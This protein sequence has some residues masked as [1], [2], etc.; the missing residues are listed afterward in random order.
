EACDSVMHSYLG[1]RVRDDRKS[2]LFGKFLSM[3]DNLTPELQQ[4]FL[5]RSFATSLMDAD[6]IE[7]MLRELAFDDIDR[8]VKVFSEQS[9]LLPERLKILV[10]KLRAST[11]DIC[12]ELQGGGIS[13]VDD[14]EIDERVAKLLKQDNDS[15]PVDKEY[16]EELKKMLGN[17][18]A[19][20]DKMTYEL[21][22]SCKS[23]IV[24]RTVSKIMFAL[25]KVESNS[26]EEYQQLL[27]GLLD[28]ADGFIETGRFSDI[29]EIY[30][31][32]R[33]HSLSGTFREEASRAIKDFFGSQIFLERLVGAFRVWGRFNTEEV[34]DLSIILKSS[35]ITPLLDA[36]SAEEN[37][38]IRRFFLDV[39]CRMGG[40][41]AT[42]AARRLDDDRWYVTRNMVHL[43]RECNGMEHVSRIRQFVKHP[44]E[45]VAMEAVRTLLHF[46][47]EDATSY[48][49]LYLQSKNPL[50]KEQ[51]ARLAGA[52]K[53]KEAVPYL[54]KLL[55]KKDMLGVDSQNKVP[56]VK[57]LGEIGEPSALKILHKICDSSSLLHKD[58]L[59]K[60]KI[61]IF[62][63]L[64]NYPIQDVKPLLESGLMSK[65]MDIR[66]I[67][68]RLLKRAG[69]E[70]D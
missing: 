11:S 3:V 21:E 34:I 8:M 19:K 50:L 42:Q 43:V 57:A 14:I 60:L 46:R 55:E 45:R 16:R 53:M 35:I 52:Y 40:D 32:V 18:K 33:T 64:H 17:P 20:N 12:F 65:I 23:E 62:R 56:A 39:L 47:T 41:V 5:T 28:L 4:K 7:T 24:D 22:D 38:S 29:S 59:E 36:L 69:E 30:N 66:L 10:D 44:D 51:A 68:E 58:E 67:S 31:T 6:E 27:S 54:V 26:K 63:S 37:T 2:E 1:R 61:E 48:V 15:A 13:Y 25:L 49:R 9:S 70:H